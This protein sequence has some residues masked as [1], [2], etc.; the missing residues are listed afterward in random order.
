MYVP[1]INT[2]EGKKPV[3]VLPNEL[4]LEGYLY[5]DA[6]TEDKEVARYLFTLDDKEYA[7]AVLRRALNGGELVVVYPGLNQQPPKGA[8]LVCSVADGALYYVKA[9]LA[10]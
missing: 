9:P 7:G 4:L 2:T 8:E 10:S 1:K 5:S 3:T 6:P